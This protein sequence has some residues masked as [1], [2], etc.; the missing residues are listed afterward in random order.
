MGVPSINMTDVVNAIKSEIESNLDSGEKVEIA[1]ALIPSQYTDVKFTVCPVTINREY[2]DA[3]DGSD[4][5]VIPRCTVR[6]WA[7]VGLVGGVDGSFEYAVA[8][9]PAESKEGVCSALEKA[10]G[11]LRDYFMADEDVQSFKIIYDDPTFVIA[12]GGSNK[13]ALAGSFKVEITGSLTPTP[14]TPLVYG[15]R[16]MATKVPFVS[17]VV[18]TVLDHQSIQVTWTTNFPATSF[19]S[20]SAGSGNPLAHGTTEDETPKTNHDVT[21]SGLDPDTYYELRPKSRDPKSNRIGQSHDRYSGTTESAGPTISNVNF[22]GIGSGIRVIYDTDVDVTCKIYYREHG[23]I[24]WLCEEFTP[25]HGGGHSHDITELTDDQKHDIYIE[26]TD[27]GGYK[28]SMPCEG[29]ENCWY[30]VLAG[31]GHE[32]YEDIHYE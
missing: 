14:E 9:I 6:V 12:E 15:T 2:T 27:D 5:I 30:E 4:T 22:T 1:P 20:Y 29:I 32:G 13:T 18:V 10:E 16:T 7:S 31:K 19:V 17:N 3:Q 28:D 26:V 25:L 21:V 11:W 24:I 8:G 23:D